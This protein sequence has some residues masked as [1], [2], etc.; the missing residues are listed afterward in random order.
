MNIHRDERAGGQVQTQA[1]LRSLALGSLAIWFNFCEEKCRNSVWHGKGARHCGYIKGLLEPWSR[2]L[3][4]SF[5]GE[6]ANLQ[7]DSC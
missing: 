5:P 7:Y 1:A 3:E 4:E 6:L 2:V